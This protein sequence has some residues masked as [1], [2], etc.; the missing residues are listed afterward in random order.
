MKELIQ[1]LDRETI[2][3]YLKARD[4]KQKELFC[5]ASAV[6]E[7]TFK[8]KIHFRGIIEF[9]NTCENNCYYCGIRKDNQKTKRFKMSL[10]EI[11]KCLDFIKK[12]NYSSVVFQSG[13]IKNQ[14]WQNYLLDI[15][16][17]ARSKYPELGITMSCGE[18]TYEFY[19]QL[20]DAGVDRY[21]LRIETSNKDLYKRL[22]PDNMSWNKRFEC[23]Q[24]LK[25]LDF[26]VGTGVMVGLPTQTL[27]DLVDD[28]IFFKRNEFDM[29]G[30]GPYVIHQDTPLA[31][32][33]IIY[34][35]NY[36]KN[37]I[38]NLALNFLAI[39]RILFPTVNIAAATAFDVF[40]PMGRIKVL[41]NGANV[42]MPSVTPSS[43]R[44]DYLLYENKPCI[45]EG[46]D[47]CFFCMTNK[48]KSVGLE[49][50]FGEQGNS[51]FYNKRMSEKYGKTTRV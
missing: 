24:W 25:D 34:D 12:A 8:N 46:A 43:L 3:N 11:E 28:L 27:D 48:I 49:P 20:K 7:E 47:K 9:S 30:I 15:L 1:S 31:T 40:D 13:E 29:Y 19:K 42:V 32:E 23:L 21:L 51:P 45:D 44:K 4:E 39:M 14:E 10:E 22:H 18:Q 16:H 38:F 2:V 41:Q 33:A 26:Q 50:M 35:W 37:E 36:R 5:L 6:R 17:L